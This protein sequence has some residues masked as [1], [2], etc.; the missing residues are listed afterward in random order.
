MEPPFIGIAQILDFTQLITAI[1]AGYVALVSVFFQRYFERRNEERKRKAEAYER[2]LKAFWN[3]SMDEAAASEYQLALTNLYV[4][5]SDEVLK[6][7]ADFHK[8][9]LQPNEDIDPNT[10]KKLYAALIAEMRRDAYLRTTALS[11]ED[12]GSRLTVFQS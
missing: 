5:A 8:Y 2:Y 3:S 6:D 1:I 9:M 4:T 11:E 12:I 7:A 10:A